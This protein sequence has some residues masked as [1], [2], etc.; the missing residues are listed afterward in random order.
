MSLK[1][2][3]ALLLSSLF[4]MFGC[5]SN[6]S[7]L[8]NI[9]M[10]WFDFGKQQALEGRLKQSEQ[11]LSANDQ[12]GYLTSSLYND[13]QLGYMKGKTE[14]CTQDASILGATGR[15]YLGIC[16][17]VDPSFQEQYDSGQDLFWTISSSD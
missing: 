16:D 6:T 10:D 7:P 15:P 5:A 14:Y 4:L 1:V 2:W 17:D 3:K 8:S 13:Y 11:K 12:D 9:P